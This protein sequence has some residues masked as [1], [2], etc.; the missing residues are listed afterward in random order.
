MDRALVLKAI[1][2]ETRMNILTLLLHHN[3]CGRALA[4]KLDL[5]EAAI[6]QHLKVLREAGLLIGEKRGYFMHYDVN[7]NVLHELA[8]NIEQL[9][10]IERELCTPEQGRCQPSER[11]RCHVNKK[12]CITEAKM[13]YH[14]PNFK[15]KGEDQREHNEHCCC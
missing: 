13:I 4:R 9:A 3:Y 12:D 14:G 2:D 5:S 15:L 10:V 11:G 1:A 7:R 8:T 6:S